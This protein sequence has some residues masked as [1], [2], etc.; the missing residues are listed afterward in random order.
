[1]I[2]VSKTKSVLS[3]SHDFVGV[4]PVAGTTPDFIRLMVYSLKTSQ[5]CSACLD[6]IPLRWNS[7]HVLAMKTQLIFASYEREMAIRRRFI[8]HLDFLAKKNLIILRCLDYSEAMKSPT[9]SRAFVLKRKAWRFFYTFIIWWL[10]SFSF[11]L[12]F[13]PELCDI[14]LRCQV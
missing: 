11:Y 10:F 2:S 12:Y 13:I 7:A 1:M 3:S 14:G 8:I 5:F 9:S 4:E 6:R